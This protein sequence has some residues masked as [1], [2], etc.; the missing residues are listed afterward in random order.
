MMVRFSDMKQPARHPK[1][2]N[3][4]AGSCAQASLTLWA[5]SEHGAPLPVCLARDPLI[6]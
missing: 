2:P 4:S 3:G 1:L 5:G 6:K